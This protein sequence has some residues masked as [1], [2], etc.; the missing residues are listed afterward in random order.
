MTKKPR[1]T[2]EEA[3]AN[4][5]KW[6]AKVVSSVKAGDLEA[7]TDEAMLMVLWDAGS[8]VGTL[9]ADLYLLIQTLYNTALEGGQ[10]DM[11][12]RTKGQFDY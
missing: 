11:V 1:M 2:P 3:Q 7:V 6:V 10:A 9:R 4:R 12:A 5:A 8:R